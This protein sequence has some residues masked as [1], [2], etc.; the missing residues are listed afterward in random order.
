M[1]PVR[2][3]EVL[4]AGG[5]SRSR[6]VGAAAELSDP[7]DSTRTGA[8]STNLVPGKGQVATPFGGGIWAGC[9]ALL[10]L[11]ALGALPSVAAAASSSDPVALRG[12]TPQVV[13]AGH[14]QLGA[15]MNP[16]QMLR[17]TLVLQPPRQDELQQFLHEVLDPRS[18]RF[19]QFLTFDEW[20]SRFAPTDAQVASVDGW[21]RGQG[22]SGVHRFG[23]NLAVKVEGPVDAVERA[24]GLR[25]NHYELGAR[26]FFSNDRDPTIPHR[27]GGLLKDVQGLNSY[28][29]VH[30]A[31]ATAAQDSVND[32]EP[33]YT[34]G[35]FLREESSRGGADRAEASAS[36]AQPQICCGEASASIELPDL[37]SSEA[38][39]YQALERFS[40]CCNPTHV[41]G[42]TP[43]QSSI[44]VIGTN[45]IDLADLSKFT[46]QYNLATNLTQVKI[47]GPSCCDG[48]MTMD[49]ETT[50][51]MANSKGSSA[52]TAHIYA[53]EGGGSS[54]GDLLDAWEEA[55]SADAARVASTSFGA[56]EDQYGGIGTPSI[57]D[58]TDAINAM[59]ASGWS[60]AAAAGDHGAYDDC[61]TLSVNFPA[62]SPNVVAL[63]GTQLSLTN[64]AGQPKFGSEPAWTGNGCAG[65]EWP[66]SNNGGGGGGCAGTEPAGY[67]QAIVTLPCGNKRALPDISL[68]SGTGA[69]IYWLGQ[70]RSIA[71]TSIAA[72]EFA[73]FLA[74]ENAY[75]TS[76]GNVCGPS[77]AGACAPI[78]MPNAMIWLMGNA[79]S[80]A[81]GHNPFYDVTSG[82]NAGSQGNG[83][84]ATAGYDL[85]TGWGSVNMLQL[86]WG[87]TD[88][89]SHGV[90]PQVSFSGPAANSWTNVDRPV[91][92]T[93]SS[94]SPQGTSAS[95]GLAGFTAQWDAVVTDV[96]THA[97][98]GSGDS[99]YD[100]PKTQGTSGSLSLAAA[101]PGCHTA[102]VRG[103]DNAGETNADQAYGP[104]CYDNQ[105]PDVT[106][107]PPDTD[108]HAADARV[109]CYAADQEGLS[110]LA[111]PADRDFA[112]TTNVAA[113]TETDNAYTGSRTVCDVAGNCVTAGPA[114]PLK[115]DKKAPAI[116]ITAPTATQYVV[117]QV[118]PAAYTCSDGGSGVASCTGPVAS[119]S[120]ID[121]TTVGSKTF[122]VNAADNVANA[123]SQSVAYASTYRICLKY[124]A[125]KPSSGRAYAFSL[126][127]CDYNNANVS[128][129]S[130]AVTATGVDGVGSRARPLGTLNPD[131][132]FLYGPGTAS[133]ASYLY[134]LDTQ[135][136][137]KTAHVLNFTVQGDPIP[138][139]APFTLK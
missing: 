58:F 124:D 25:L 39:D 109:N 29:R 46:T 74:R 62:S 60:I 65:S 26:R 56:F 68:N 72:P 136:L 38:Y 3:H 113:G 37:F 35:P 69:S 107:F 23:N 5:R 122:T 7:A 81:N 70:W 63:G 31:G 99:F 53:Y 139:I 19:H 15:H 119:G 24:F 127:L 116:S 133:G 104:V 67:W 90:L 13:K 112:L 27:L 75:L 52:D 28:A 30:P 106:C 94:P 57:S 89:I 97:T 130:I 123:S 14:A 86:A 11:V 105:P 16:K 61:K 18:P 4:V 59:T 101:G 103:W 100:G 79:G 118:V 111:D 87:L 40:P 129:A 85:A 98:P 21:A 84:C 54:L 43:K 49:I 131:N 80:S 137:A 34:P 6:D 73:A 10:V 78:G 51:A 108:W 96:K 93:V 82:C 92:F 76:L 8:A 102:H 17:L 41:L 42:G 120:A 134:N 83:Y 9:S 2:D 135:G 22:L 36:V 110:G 50:I 1:T 47:N 48:E 66:G 45:T 88:V 33:I 91:G 125:S 64:N 77:F 115:V 20:K 44:A 32:S 132:K 71:G 114:G 95:V 121:T 126:Q 117:K 128:D 55:H 138:H 12:V